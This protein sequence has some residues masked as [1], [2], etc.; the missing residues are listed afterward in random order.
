[1]AGKSA[2]ILIKILTDTSKLTGLKG[3][4]QKAFLP[5]TAVLGGLTAGLFKL[6]DAG[7]ESVTSNSRLEQVF[8]S[9]GDTTGTAAKNAQD[10]AETLARQIGVDDD[11]IKSTEA[12][13][14]TFKAVSNATALQAGIFQRATNAA[15]DLAATGF[16]EME[17]NA[18]Q[19]G[20]A[21]QDPVKGLTALAKAGVTFT[22]QEK[23]KIKTL[24]ESGNQLEAQKVILSA[25]ESQVGGVA[26][27]TA[28]AS[29]IQGV[30]WD[31]AAQSLGE[32]LLP[33]MDRFSKTMA[34]VA[35]F[36]ANNT[37]L[38]LTFAGVLG[39]L[40]TVVVTVNA[41]MA[42]WKTL[43]S[44]GALISDIGDAFQKMGT[45]AKIATASA[46][47]VGI[48]LT[49]LA[50]IY[51]AIADK[52]AR[53]KQ[54]ADDFTAALQ[55]S[56]GVIDENVTL[57]ARKKLED[58]GAL[59]AAQNL[60]LNLDT[61]TQAALGNASALQIVNDRLAESDAKWTGAASATTAEAKAA[62]T[63]RTALG[64]TSTALK[65]A[66]DK[67][68][69]LGQTTGS[70]TS[71]TNT[72]TGATEDN[73]EANKKNREEL[74]KLYSAR[75]KLA[76]GRIAL[77]ASFD[78]ATKAAKDNGKTLDVTTEKGRANR[79]A[80]IDI[81]NAA[82]GVPSQMER[83]RKKFIEV[84]EA[85]GKSPKAAAD[86]ADKWGLVSDS[87]K[88][89]AASTQK[90]AD[91]AKRLIKQAAD[92]TKKLKEL[93][94]QAD[95]LGDKKIKF[96]VSASVNKSADEIVYS[97]DGG[98]RM[99]FTAR[100][101]GGRVYA[102]Q[103]Y[104]V[105]EKRPELFFPDVNGRIEPQVPAAMTSAGIDYERLADAIASRGISFAVIAGEVTRHQAGA[106]RRS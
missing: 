64:D 45:K 55:A 9:M 58:A 26:K 48:A 89:A 63:L 62:G 12:K 8:R 52:Q 90:M 67:A 79:Q 5:A 72:N 78:A 59:L 23:A 42:V 1:M 76:G 34:D 25:I 61:V 41:A 36:T 101:F 95:K 80:L 32:A 29:E 49:A 102:G 20:K 33:M 15:A 106:Y 96:S 99:K 97:V 13:L 24:V 83:S 6:R 10:Y 68:Y 16:G 71:A 75:L 105:G 18:T 3:T 7:E 60:G 103:G 11:V 93:Q 84:A 56:N 40:A 81:A 82:Q 28:N 19:L 87:S 27:A 21:L 50:I 74:D 38:V 14:A 77:E 47:A 53:A 65:D 94:V 88:K 86:L 30:A 66:E 39:G 54:S 37:N 4:F 70:A 22:A 31:N 43:S 91:E 69:R 73:T 57:T 44:V 35:D 2:S 104:L 100:E 17:S 92:A 85:M 46:G 98:G 51:G